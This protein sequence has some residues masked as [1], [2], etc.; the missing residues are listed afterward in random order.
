MFQVIFAEPQGSSEHSSNTAAMD[1]RAA[2]QC[3]AIILNLIF[4]SATFQFLKS[5]G[6]VKRV[7]KKNYTNK[8]FYNYTSLLNESY[9]WRLDI[10]FAVLVRSGSKS[11]PRDSGIVYNSSRYESL[12][13][14]PMSAVH[15]IRVHFDTS[16]TKFS[17]DTVRRREYGLSRVRLSVLHYI[18]LERYEKFGGPRAEHRH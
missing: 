4:I 3:K 6:R 11:P 12:I 16:D 7:K 8:I 5:R 13:G 15:I 10:F 1:K 14:K 18:F 17:K 9:F 2:G